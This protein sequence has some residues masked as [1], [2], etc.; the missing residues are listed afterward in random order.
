[1]PE[2]EKQIVKLAQRLNPDNLQTL[3]DYLDGQSELRRE[4]Q[5]VMKIHQLAEQCDE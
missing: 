4:L 3:I 5:T 1:M 2:T